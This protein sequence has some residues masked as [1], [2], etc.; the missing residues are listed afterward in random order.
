MDA[1]AIQIATAAAAAA[2]AAA[3][4]G[5]GKL[6]A[7]QIYDITLGAAETAGESAV[8]DQT[9]SFISGDLGLDSGVV[10]ENEDA[11]YDCVLVSTR[12]SL[13][14]EETPM[15][16]T[17]GICGYKFQIFNKNEEFGFSFDILKDNAA[18][19]DFGSSL[20][21]ITLALF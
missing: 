10:D 3:S 16:L 15:P 4:A 1:I 8:N 2:A 19:L 20:L 21:A 12:P 9:D 18:A 17:S 14:T 13:Y 5:D 7:K 6:T 11:E